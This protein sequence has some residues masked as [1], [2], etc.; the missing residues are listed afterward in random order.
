MKLSCF[1][2]KFRGLAN[3][4]NHEHEEAAQRVGKHAFQ[5]SKQKT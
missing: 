4:L 2:V 1:R 5:L 3:Q